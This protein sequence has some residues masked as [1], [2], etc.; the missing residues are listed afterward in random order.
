MRVSC[1]PQ[2]PGAPPC[3][4]TPTGK[5]DCPHQK[6]CPPSKKISTSYGNPTYPTMYTLYGPTDESKVVQMS[7]KRPSRHA[8]SPVPQRLAPP[9]ALDPARFP[10]Q[11]CTIGASLQLAHMP[12]AAQSL[13]HADASAS[14][15][16]L[17]Q[18]TQP[19][20]SSYKE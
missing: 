7:C 13:H 14:A 2:T 15:S 1:P 9:I 19:I 17:P 18:L 3:P 16:T 8:P 11:A 4:A 10:Q 12:G 20:H 6:K 5:H